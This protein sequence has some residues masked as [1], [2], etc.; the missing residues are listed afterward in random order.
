[1][2]E[3]DQDTNY[4]TRID[5]R[6]SWYYEAIG[7]TAG[8]QGRILNFGQVYWK[9]PRSRTATGSMAARRIGCACRAI[10]Q[11]CSSGR[12]HCTTT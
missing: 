11:W 2:V 6:G 9:P 1:M 10:R 8:I 7:K 5:E 3:L 4:T 12:S